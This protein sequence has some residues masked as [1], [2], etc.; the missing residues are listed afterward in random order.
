VARSSSTTGI[1]GA[2]TILVSVAIY[3]VSPA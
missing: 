1:G 3:L 2:P